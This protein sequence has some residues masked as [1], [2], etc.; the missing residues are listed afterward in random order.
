MFQNLSEIDI[1]QKS[2]IAPGPDLVVCDE[3]HLLKNDK[4]QLNKAVNRV[5]TMRR[6]ILTGTPLQNDLSE[7]YCMVQFVKPNLLGTYN[8]FMTEFVN[9]ITK[10]QYK[11]STEP[12][13]LMM[14]RRSHILHN[15]LDGCVQRRDC[16]VLAPFLPRKQEFAIYIRLTKLQVNLYKVRISPETKK[17]G[18]NS[19]IY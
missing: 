1:F 7:Y 15:L 2:L 5:K 17:F 11:N 18:K 13:V 12:E 3:G 19:C 14:K 16:S 9:P 10:G 8:E 4:K 6:I